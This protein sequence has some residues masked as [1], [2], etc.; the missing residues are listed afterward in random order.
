MDLFEIEGSEQHPAYQRLESTNTQRQYDF[1]NSMIVAALESGKPWISQWLIKALNFHAIVGLHSEAGKY[2]SH[3]VVVGDYRPPAHFRVEP[4]MDEFV[5][6]VNWNHQSYDAMTLAAYVLWHVNS[7]HPFVNGNGRTARA[8]AYYVLCVKAGGPIPGRTIL[9]EMLTQEPVRSEYVGALK[10]A[11]KGSIDALIEL[12][13]R[14][15]TR[16]IL[17]R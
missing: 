7:I 8:A 5:H 10:E 2:R 11:D 16:Q 9:P 15:V 13:R 1:L 3:A 14:L 6:W 12:V 4:L 17:D